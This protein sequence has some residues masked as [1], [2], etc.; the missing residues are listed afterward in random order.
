MDY[1]MLAVKAGFRSGKLVLP[2]ALQDVDV[3]EVR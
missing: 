1:V 2:V 3:K